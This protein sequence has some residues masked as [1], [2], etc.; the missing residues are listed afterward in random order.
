MSLCIVAS[1]VLKFYAVPKWGRTS[2]LPFVS[3]CSLI[4]GISVSCTQGVGASVVTS[5]GGYV[6][7]SLLFRKE[8]AGVVLGHLHVW[9]GELI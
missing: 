9:S 4:G 3:I 7:P 2:M 8:C 1:L 5:I 6:S